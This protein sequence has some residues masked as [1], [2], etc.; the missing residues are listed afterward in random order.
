MVRAELKPGGKM[1]CQKYEGR[2]RRGCSWST[3]RPA[4]EMSKLENGS[5]V[6]GLVA[7]ASAVVGSGPG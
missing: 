2:Q 1:S 5:A 3:G 4:A 7:V 6:T